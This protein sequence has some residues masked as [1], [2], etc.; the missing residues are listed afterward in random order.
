MLE[1][2]AID[3]QVI[4]NPLPIGFPF[5]L[6]MVKSCFV[7]CGLLSLPLNKVVLMWS[8]FST[9]DFN[10]SMKMSFEFVYLVHYDS[11]FVGK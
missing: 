7:L 6:S 8:V 9:Y 2:E 5:T 4:H 11:C 1:E 10:C 3:V